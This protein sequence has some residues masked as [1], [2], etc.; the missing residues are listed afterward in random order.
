MEFD[1]TVLGEHYSVSFLDQTSVLVSGREREYILY[2]TKDWKC[3][4]NISI[5]LVSLLGEAIERHLAVRAA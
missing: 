3:A 2:K 5:E 4:D 1:T